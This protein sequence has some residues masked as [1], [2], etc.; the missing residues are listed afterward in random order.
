MRFML[1]N[2]LW[3]IIF[4]RQGLAKCG[5]CLHRDSVRGF[6]SEIKS[7]QMPDSV[8]PL[9]WLTFPWCPSWDTWSTSD[10][11]P[12]TVLFILSSIGDVAFCLGLANCKVIA[13]PIK[14][15]SLYPNL[16]SLLRVTGRS[17]ILFQTTFRMDAFRYRHHH[18]H[19]RSAIILLVQ[20]PTK[21]KRLVRLFSLS[22]DITRTII[23]NEK[24]QYLVA[25]LSTQTMCSRVWRVARVAFLFSC[26]RFFFLGCLMPES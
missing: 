18:L 13:L 11:P 2:E 3:R 9:A 19:V 12:P 15:K 25:Y 10:I 20:S 17:D 8:S 6:T 1:V 24:C 4:S 23:V 7:C 21:E 26:W 14:Y 5:D 22:V 16:S